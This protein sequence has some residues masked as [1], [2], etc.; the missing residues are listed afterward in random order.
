VVIL[1]T[2]ATHATLLQKFLGEIKVIQTWLQTRKHTNGSPAIQQMRYGKSLFVSVCASFENL[3]YP[4]NLRG[5]NITER[6][7]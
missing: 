3:D 4:I 2:V 1:L 6:K 7:S 5:L